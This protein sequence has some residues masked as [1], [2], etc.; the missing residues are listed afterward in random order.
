MKMQ[1]NTDNL[2][3]FKCLSS[4]T[5]IKIIEL[6]NH[7]TKN[8]GEL[9]DILGV[10]SAIIT[11]HINSL[12]QC[13]IIQTK[14]VPGKRG[15]QKICSLST[16]EVTLLFNKKNTK[17]NLKEVSLPV[18]QYTN[19]QVQPTC[20]LAA[21]DGLIGICDDP[22]YFSNPD[23]FNA[24]IIWFQTGWVE[25][26]IPGYIFSAKPL[27][28]IQISLELCSEFP[29]YK[30]EWPSDIYFYLNDTLLG[31]WQSPGDFGDKSGT[32][33]PEWWHL[34][35]KYGLLKT[36]TVTEKETILDGIKLS[37]TTLEEIAPQPGED[38]TLRIAVPEDTQN[39]GGI[40]IFGKGFGNYDQN[41]EVSVSYK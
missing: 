38:M 4:K 11:R 24:G 25:Y 21:P 12:E 26:C 9:A 27:E 18:G 5:R 23:R 31:S 30:Q 3:F 6:L 28:Y 36:I 2:N 1:V 15:L 8:I 20:G 14:N 7:E 35:T 32:Y 39:R 29:G 13:N 33:T 22:R 17:N 19:Y 16:R 10:S 37:N 34:G 40:T 41:I